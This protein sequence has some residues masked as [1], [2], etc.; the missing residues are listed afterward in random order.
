[1]E[2]LDHAIIV[3]GSVY[4]TSL[5]W[6][7]NRILRLADADGGNRTRAASAASDRAIHYTIAPRLPPE[8]IYFAETRFF[9]VRAWPWGPRGHPSKNYLQGVKQPLKNCLP[10]DPHVKSYLTLLRRRTD[11]QTD[12]LFWIPCTPKE[13]FFCFLHLCE[14]EGGKHYKP[15]KIS[16]YS[17]CEPRFA[18]FTREGW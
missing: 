11:R 7:I 12:T 10:F 18:C 13:I 14:G 8:E 9:G 15:Y 17:L 1:M 4:P 6:K 3:P 5:C 2:M 16:T